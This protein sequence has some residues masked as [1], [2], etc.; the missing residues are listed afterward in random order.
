MFP[1]LLKDMK[2]Y[3]D[4]QPD[5]DIHNVR[6]GKSERVLSIG[7]P[8]PVKLGYVTLLDQ[9]CLP[10]WKLSEPCTIWILWRLRH[11]G[12]IND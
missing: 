4:K 5:E 10:T 9:M 11:I 12:K 1:S 3:A 8:V 7:A 6:S 2:K